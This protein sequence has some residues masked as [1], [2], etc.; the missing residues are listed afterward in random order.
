[1]EEANEELVEAF[2]SWKPSQ[3]RR[4][5]KTLQQTLAEEAVG[6]QTRGRARLAS[7]LREAAQQIDSLSSCG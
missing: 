5:L 7:L 6:D 4:F 2:I 3:Q 1:M